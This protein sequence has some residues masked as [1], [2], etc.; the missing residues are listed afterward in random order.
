MLSDVLALFAA[1]ALRHPLITCTDMRRAEDAFRRVSQGL[2]LGKIVLTLGRALTLGG[3]VLITGGTGA[4]GRA[5]GRHLAARHGVSRIVLASRDGDGD[6][7]GA[8]VVACDVANREATAAMLAKHRPTAIV[9]MAGILDDVPFSGLTAERLDAVLA[10][11]VGG[12]V[13]LHELTR[14]S[15]LEAFVLYSSAMSTLG[16]AGQ[17]AYAAANAFLDA[18]ARHRRARGLPGVA[19]AWGPWE[20]GMAASLGPADRARMER[21]G[22]RPVSADE[23]LALFDRALA[24]DEPFVIPARLDAAALRLRRHNLVTA[25]ERREDV[26]LSARLARLD[27]QARV[28]AVL[29]VVR[30]NAAIVLGHSSADGVGAD[31]SFRDLGFDSLS[32][33]E[34]RNRLNAVT[35]LRLPPTVIFNQP[36]PEVL[37]RHLLEQMA[38]QPPVLTELGRLETALAAPPDAELR[39]Q[40]GTRLL[41]LAA[42]LMDR[43]GAPHAAGPEV[44]DVADRLQTASVDEL[45]SFID[46]DANGG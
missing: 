4:L 13:N 24:A 36:T 17:A 19:L 1:G 11:K 28:R 9:H 38:P 40:V 3:T 42:R 27:A 35:G 10:A 18:L 8:E 43:E 44:R 30:S 46:R 15:D 16:G 5:L 22:L 41:A 2:H 31:I 45:L 29:D 20:A 32:S 34:L 6:D 33:I 23:G 7:A 14:E 21:T 37:T 26:P 12:A 25:G 39:T